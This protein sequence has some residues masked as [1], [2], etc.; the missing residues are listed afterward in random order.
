MMGGMGMMGGTGM[1]IMGGTA[2]AMNGMSIT[3]DGEKEMPPI[4]TL[5][6][7]QSYVLTLP[8]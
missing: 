6:R 1:M 5:R 7:G 4:L 3:G 8:Q 2:W